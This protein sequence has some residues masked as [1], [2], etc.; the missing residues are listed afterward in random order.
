VE[1]ARDLKQSAEMHRR[2]YRAVRARDPELSRREMEEHLDKARQAQA[3]E[4]QPARPPRR[5]VR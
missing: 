5:A 4:D 1:R 3:S 2:I